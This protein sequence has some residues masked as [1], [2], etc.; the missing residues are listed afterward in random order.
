MNLLIYVSLIDQ[1]LNWTLPVLKTIHDYIFQV[2]IQ[3]CFLVFYSGKC[4]VIE[5]TVKHHNQTS[6]CIISS[7]Q[8]AIKVFFTVHVEMNVLERLQL[9]LLV[10]TYLTNDIASAGN[11]HHPG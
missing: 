5:Q 8:R 1:D 6:V 11:H 9:D 10:F 7:F 4:S 3:M 2:C